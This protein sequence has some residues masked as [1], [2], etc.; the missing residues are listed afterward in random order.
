MTKIET[1]RLVLREFTPQ[2]APFVLDL[3]NEPSWLENIGDKNVHSLKDAENYIKNGPLKSY[4]EYGF[5]LYVAELRLKKIPV[6]MC[7][8]VQRDYLES[9]DIGFAFLPDYWGAGLATEA[10]KAVVDYANKDL[11]I[12]NVLGITN[13]ENIGSMKVLEKVGLRFDKFFE[14]P[15][16]KDT[17]RLFSPLK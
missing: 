4:Q 10:A 15:D 2:D 7:G 8:L 5:G 16:S 13:P 17:I 12:N 9:P 3:V 1:D 6:G 14:L 11:Q